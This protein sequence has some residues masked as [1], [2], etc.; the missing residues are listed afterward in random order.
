MSWRSKVVW[1]EGL[2]LRPQHFQ[3]ETRYLE[4]FVE[5]RS[6][7]LR[8]YSWGFSEISIDPDLLRIGK[9]GIAKAVGVMP[10]GT[11]I[12]IPDDDPVPTAVDVDENIREC[13]VYLS[14]PTRRPAAQDIANV[15]E[16]D[17]VVRHVVKDYEARDQTTSADSSV[18]M[19]VGGLHSRLLLETDERADYAYMGVAHITEARTNGEVVL[20][21]SFLAPVL[22]V[23]AERRLGGFITELQGLLHH[24]GE[25]LAGR[26]SA[27]GKGGAAEVGEFLMLSLVNRYEPLFA[28]SATLKALHPE[29]LFKMLI[30]L[31]GELSTYTGDAK[32]PGQLPTYRHDDLRATF[33]PLMRTLRDLLGIIIHRAAVPIPLKER[34]Y[35]FKTAELPEPSLVDTASFVLAVSAAVPVEDLQRRFPS[36]LKIGSYHDIRDLVQRQLPGIRT[37]PLAAAPR[38]LPFYA[39]Y[40]YFELDKTSPESKP[41][42]DAVKEGGRF[43]MHVPEQVFPSLQMEFWAIKG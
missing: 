15:D 26:V 30:A 7:H 31:V 8:P 3:Q 18:L 6:G 29:D 37:R 36:T 2:F 1:S 16:T 4:H 32:R 33:E 24:R 41:L 12:N 25:E 13:V 42:W 19:Q 17:V 28:H 21:E 9:V 20:D 35:G 23:Q 5:L 40:S 39:D 27:S 11:P 22:D 38:Q 34:Q 14:V 10:D 43:G